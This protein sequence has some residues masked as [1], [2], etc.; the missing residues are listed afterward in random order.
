MKDTLLLKTF[1][2]AAF[3]LTLF[4]TS[5]KSERDDTNDTF[6]SM[7]DFYNNHR[8]QEQEFTIDSAGKGPIIG[9]QNT[10]L[11][12]DTSIFMFPGGG[13]LTF[14]F[15]VKLI[16]L[17]PHSDFMEFPMSTFAGTQVTESAGAIRV[18]VFKNGTELVLKP[19]KH[20]T[21]VMTDTN[22]LLSNMKVFFGSNADTDVSWTQTTDASTVTT[23][24]NSY[25]LAL[26]QMGWVNCARPHVS[27]SPT[28][29]VTFTAKGSGTQFIDVYIVAKDYFSVVKVSNLK[30]IPL[31]IGENV[32]IIAMAMDQNKKYRLQ[33]TSTTI[34]A[35]MTVALDLQIVTEQDV[36]NALNA[37]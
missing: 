8:Q 12:L 9:K 20:Y 3:L 11:Y 16:E 5:C 28:T 13:D 33:N 30:S 2:A 26:Y 7:D 6:S 14:P 18:R 21:T 10:Q 34:T 4:V 32:T 23:N 29:T 22:N 27:S 19:G 35:G 31:P 37:L 1:A 36:L 17:Y 24:N 15:T 25:G